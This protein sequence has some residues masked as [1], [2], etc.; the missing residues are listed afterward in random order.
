MIDVQR[1]GRMIA[2]AP[3]AL[4]TWAVNANGFHRDDLKQ[5]LQA[6]TA[7][8]I[9]FL[10][11]DEFAR[12]YAKY[13]ARNTGRPPKKPYGLLKFDIHNDIKR[14]LEMARMLHEIGLPGL[15]LMMPRHPMNE[16]FYDHKRTW[17]ILREIQSLG[18]EVGLHAD[19]FD[20]IATYGD[21]Y[22]GLKASVDDLR[23]RGLTIRSATVHGDTRKHIKAVRMQAN[24]F[25]KEGYR[26]TKWNGNPPKG[27]EFYAQHVRCY[28]HR[29]IAEECGLEY[30]AEVKF[31]EKGSAI[32]RKQMLYLSDNRRSLEIRNVAGRRRKNLVCEKEFAITP[33]FTAAAI[34]AL[35]QRPFLSLLHPQ[36]Y[37]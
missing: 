26:R 15:F 23:G 16:G 12:R 25:F 8:G 10:A 5:F 17:E 2:R 36:W 22:K 31:L 6:L 30:F 28:S 27:Q 37:R 13:S 19:V 7:S 33:E 29:R 9:K 34:E 20:L 4:R 1:L 21:L 11:V 14:P 18:H 24:D 35:K 32:A 3:R